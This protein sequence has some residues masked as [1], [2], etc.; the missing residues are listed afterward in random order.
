MT[1]LVEEEEFNCVPRR[2]LP[3]SKQEEEKKEPNSESINA[4]GNLF[5]PT[6]CSILNCALSNRVDGGYGSGRVVNIIG[7]SHAGKTILALTGLAEMSID[8][9]WDD[10]QLLFS[11]VERALSFD[12]ERLFGRRLRKRLEAGWELESEICDMEEYSPPVTIQEFYQRILKRIQSGQ[13]FIE[14]LDSF[15]SLTSS[16]EVDRA[17]VLRDKGKEAGS[18]KMEK[19]RWASEVFRVISSGLSN[20]G[21]LLIVISQTR[22]NI[23]PI[24][25][26]KK[27]RSGGKALEFYSSHIFWLSKLKSI[28]QGTKPKQ[29]KVGRHVAAKITKTKLTGYEGEVHFPVYRQIGIDDIGA[30]IEFLIEWSPRWKKKGTGICCEELGLQ[31]FQKTVCAKAEREYQEEIKE[32]LQEAWDEYLSAADIGRASRFSHSDY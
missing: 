5:I 32:H 26:Q 28:T 18:Y 23:D 19:A 17:D 11:D 7:D 15:D 25:F 13:P 20:T 10:Y 4:G 16:E 30:S 27:T 6:G 31:G 24:G 2:K 3:Q 9:Q 8:T 21:S 22:D 29:I 1:Q 12:I 14:V